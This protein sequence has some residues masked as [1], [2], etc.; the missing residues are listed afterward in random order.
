MSF[1]RASR[2]DHTYSSVLVEK[3][4]T[5]CE[6]GFAG[7]FDEGGEGGESDSSDLAVWLAIRRWSS[8]VS[9]QDDVQ[10]R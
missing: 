6:R 3:R 9:M 7:S 1:G 2:V 10:R 8:L 5:W 4:A